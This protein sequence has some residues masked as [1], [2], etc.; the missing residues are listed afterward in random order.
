MAAQLALNLAL[1]DEG[2]VGAP[3]NQRG[4][5]HRHRSQGHHH[6]GNQRVNGQHEAQRAHNG[7]HAGK[8]LGEA[9]QQAIAH[10]VHIADHPVDNVAMGR[11]VNVLER[12]MDQA[13]KHLHPQVADRLVAHGIGAKA[14]QPL[15]Q[16][17]RHNG[18][19]QQQRVMADDRK[20]HLP[21]AEDG[22]HRVSDE[23]RAQKRHHHIHQRAAKR[24]HKIQPVGPHKAHQPAEN[25]LATHAPAS[26]L[27][28]WDAQ[29]S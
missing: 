16:R 22:V 13:G 11:G 14:H 2:L 25:L 29:I 28:I 15:E 21:G 3:G 6:Q 9:L 12:H 18:R 23:H 4:D 19:R 24:E 8:Q 10:C 1:F 7:R 27:R 17:A 20:I 5:H 26:S